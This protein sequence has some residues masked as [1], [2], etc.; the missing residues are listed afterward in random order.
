MSPVLRRVGVNAGWLMAGRG[1]Q[2][3]L[4]IAYLAI[5]TRTLGLVD[6]GKFTLVVAVGQAISALVG[7]QTWQFVVRYGSQALAAQDERAL[8]RVVGVAA[9]LDFAAAALGCLIAL[10]V[11]VLATRWVGLP[12]DLRLPAFG[13]CAAMLIAVRSTPTGVLR[14]DQRFRDAA[15]ADAALPAVRT[16]GALAAALWL[17]SV[18]GLLWAWAAAE[19]VTAAVTWRTAMKHR[20][21]SLAPADL[22]RFVREEP[23]F[24]RFVLM[25]NLSSTLTM[26]AKQFTLILIGAFSGPAAAGL[27]RVAAQLAQALAKATQTFSRAAYSELV[28]A[29]STGSDRALLRQLTLVAGIAAAAMVGIAALLGEPLLHLIATRQ[30]SGAYWPVVILVG[31]AGLDL[32]GFAF[33]PAMTARGQTSAA[34]WLRLVSTGALVALLVLL[35]PRFGVVGGAWATFGGSLAAL[36]LTGWG[37]FRQPSASAR[38]HPSPSQAPV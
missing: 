27:F 12:D 34:F 11:I 21:L 14:L 35:L 28:E 13:F 23:G 19:L 2:A 30:F 6:F 29:S 5:A 7:F 26:T 38:A 32:V 17:P 10:G 25:T 24:W 4:S 8:A 3:V 33:E 16:L 31:A 22:K 15:V 36:L 37:V 1:F 20:R 18:A 9:V